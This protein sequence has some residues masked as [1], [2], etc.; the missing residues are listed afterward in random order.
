MF[1]SSTLTA[2]PGLR[3]RK[4]QQTRTRIIDVALNLC[5][6]QGFDA[7]TV[8]QIAAEA[9]VSPRTVNRYFASKEDIVI[10]P[11]EDWGQALAE[12][13]RAQ[14][15]TGNELQAL[16][17]AFLLVVEQILGGDN[18]VPFRWFQQM[19][20]VTRDN[21]AVR[22]QSLEAADTKTR[23]M[24]EVLAERLR[25]TPD[26]APVR[27]I[28]ATWHSIVRVGMECEFDADSEF[29]DCTTAGSARQL[30]DN[31]QAAY[32]EFVRVCATPTVASPTSETAAASR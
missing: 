29:P 3:E 25:T 8:E 6:T 30:A 24:A 15:V 18:P 11:I 4:K 9:D 21:V 16:L 1:D 26:A 32:D 5:D 10:A 17:D 23:A 28:A 12:Q 27:M 13:L 2:R 7:T 20:R 31:V 22:A 19:Q 14:P